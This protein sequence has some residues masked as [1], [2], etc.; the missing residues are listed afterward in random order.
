EA[1]VALDLGDHVGEP[2]V[3][4]VDVDAARELG[5]LVRQLARAPV[6]DLGDLATETID[7]LDDAL[8][9][10]RRLVGLDRGTKDVDGFVF[11]RP[12]DALLGIGQRIPPGRWPRHTRQSEERGVYV[13][14][15]RGDAITGAFLWCGGP[16]SRAPDPPRSGSRGPRRR[17]PGDRRARRARPWRNPR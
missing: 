14:D 13:A 16:A 1:Q 11:T 9:H 8:G 6:V 15:R 10:L 5:D 12:T 17:D 2:D 7:D 3:L 4:H